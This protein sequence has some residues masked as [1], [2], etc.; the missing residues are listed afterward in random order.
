MPFE[1]SFKERRKYITSIRH[2]E[3]IMDQV[4]DPNY[5]R[6]GKSY[7]NELVNMEIHLIR[8]RATGLPVRRH[9]REF[10]RVK[11]ELKRRGV[12]SSEIRDASAYSRDTA[13]LSLILDALG[14]AR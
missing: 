2:F 13:D 7:L 5:H 10:R 8:V 4:M 6:P 14:E 3:A 12:S 9:Y 1:K 11:K